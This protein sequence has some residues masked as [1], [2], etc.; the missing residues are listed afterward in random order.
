MKTNV[1]QLVFFFECVNPVW[2]RSLNPYTRS[3]SCGG[4]SGGE[5]A[6][7]AMDGAAL[8]WGSDIGGSLRSVETS[9]TLVKVLRQALIQSCACLQDSSFILWGLLPQARLGPDQHCR[10]TWCVYV[11]Y[12]SPR[13]QHRCYCSAASP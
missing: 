1:A 3:Y 9:P 4:T 2:G 7:L 13:L 8:G 10:C 5:A 11:R 12:L 6:L